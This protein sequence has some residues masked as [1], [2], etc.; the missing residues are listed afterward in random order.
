MSTKF[1]TCTL[2]VLFRG[3][4]D[5]GDIQGGP[6]YFIE[7]GLGKRFKPLA[8]FFSFAGM[9]ASFT[10]FQANQLLSLIHI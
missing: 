2:A 1:F 4:D 6:M 7:E 9:F 3:K 10:F 5:N 8:I